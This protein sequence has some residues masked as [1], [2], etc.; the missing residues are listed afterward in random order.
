MLIRQSCKQKLGSKFWIEY[1]IFT[2]SYGKKRP[3][4]QTST[5]HR[6]ISIITSSFYPVLS[7]STEVAGI[8]PLSV[9]MTLLHLVWLN[10]STIT[11]PLHVL[12]EHPF[13]LLPRT[14][15]SNATFNTSSMLLPVRYFL[16][17]L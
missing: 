10:A 11:F 4:T 9:Q 5:W 15:K 6:V 1:K 14:S 13:F 7:A 2:I 3:H 8:T 12:F 16:L 17:R